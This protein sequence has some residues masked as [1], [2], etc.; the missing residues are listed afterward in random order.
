M[1]TDPAREFTIAAEPSLSADEFVDVL[2]RSTL[3][4]RRPVDNA[5]Q[6]AGMLAHAHVVLT[7]RTPEGALVGVSRAITDFHYCTYLSDLA[8]DVDYQGRGVGRRL[9]EETHAVAG[10]QT[11]LI[12]LSAPAARGYYPHIGME[13]H[14]SCW[15]IRPTAS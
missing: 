4:E 2:R 6:I 8:V 12:L 11:T 15:I 1:P 3:A 5:D 13:Q 10:R 14:D 7:A 9:I